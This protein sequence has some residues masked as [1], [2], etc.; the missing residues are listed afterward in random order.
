M[1]FAVTATRFRP[2]VSAPD[3]QR[4]AVSTASFRLK[5]SCAAPKNKEEKAKREG[6]GERREGDPFVLSTSILIPVRD[7]TLAR[8]RESLKSVLP[9]R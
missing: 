9:V 3:L 4:A 2:A 7:S 8:S 6:G 5:L 1:A